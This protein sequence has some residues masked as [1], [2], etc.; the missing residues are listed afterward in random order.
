MKRIWIFTILLAL[1]A[2]T[3][4]LHEFVKLPILFEHY[5]EHQQRK[6]DLKFM[7]FL[8]MHYWG[9]DMDDDDNS[10][11]MELPF[12]KLEASHVPVHFL[13]PRTGIKLK[14]AVFQI[15]LDHPEYL[16]LYIPNPALS[17][18]FRPPCA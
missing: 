18:L 11:D 1:L 17:A 13:P 6:S 16:P 12:K 4:E 2:Q 10:R 14:S 7:E 3:T 5:A 8:S 9:D 15:R